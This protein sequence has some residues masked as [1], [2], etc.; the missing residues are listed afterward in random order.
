MSG[1]KE[2]IETKV[3]YTKSVKIVVLITWIFWMLFISWAYFDMPFF[4]YRNTILY[5]IGVISGLWFVLHYVRPTVCIRGTEVRWQTFL[6]PFVYRKTSINN[7][8]RVKLVTQYI[9][10]WGLSDFMIFYGEKYRLFSVGMRD[11]NAGK[12]YTAV[13]SQYGTRIQDQRTKKNPYKNRSARR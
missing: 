11:V 6:F 4:D 10:D 7:I 9:H 13:A 2:L 12:L 5:I 1:K 8:K 3:G